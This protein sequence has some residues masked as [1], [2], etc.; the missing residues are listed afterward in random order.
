MQTCFTNPA[1]F[2]SMKQFYVTQGQADNSKNKMQQSQYLQNSSGYGAPLASPMSQS[3]Q[4]PMGYSGE[5]EES[6][7]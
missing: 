7:Y 3:R 2:E 6:R 4:V 5:E 1:F